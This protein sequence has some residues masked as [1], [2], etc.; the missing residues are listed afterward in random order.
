MDRKLTVQAKLAILRRM[1]EPKA[2]Q[3]NVAKSLGVSRK[4]V[5]N[6]LR[7]RKV[8]TQMTTSVDS[9]KRYRLKQKLKYGDIDKATFEWFRRMRE[10]HGEFPINET[11]VC[12]KALKLAAALNV[13][14]FKA[15]RGWFRSWR[16]RYGLK[17]FKVILLLYEC[18]TYRFVVKAHLRQRI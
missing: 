7:N 12:E 6:V 5:Q 9:R 16:N 8:L 3:R 17:L 18:P 4:T 11:V 2:T 15:S 1:E 10:K 13:E 14:G